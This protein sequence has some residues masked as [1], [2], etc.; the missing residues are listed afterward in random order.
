MLLA[1][2]RDEALVAGLHCETRYADAGKYSTKS[3]FAAANALADCF[4]LPVD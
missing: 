2:F 4:G 3:G 1:L